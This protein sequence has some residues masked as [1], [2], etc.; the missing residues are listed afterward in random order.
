[1]ANGKP[2]G[3]VLV[4]AMLL[5][6]SS[7]IALDPRMAYLQYDFGTPPT[8]VNLP[9]EIFDVTQD[10]GGFLWLATASGLIRYDGLEATSYRRSA[11]PGLPSNNVT[12]LFVDSRGRLFVSSERGT[13]FRDNDAFV[14]LL[15]GSKS[16]TQAHAFAEGPAG[17]IWIGTNDALLRF[18]GDRVTAIESPDAPERI[19]SLLWY[20]DR[21]YIGGRARIWIRNG[22]SLSTIELPPGFS[23]AHVRDLVFHQGH[24]WAAT[25]SGLFRLE[26]GRAV[27]VIREELDGLA[28]EDLLAD[29]DENLWFAGRRFIGR[30]LPDGRIEIPDLEDNALGY[31]PEITALYE[32]AAGQHWHTSRFFGLNSVRD[33]PVSRVSYA[34]GLPSTNVTALAANREGKIFVATDSGVSSVFEGEIVTV[35]DGD[36]S[37]GRSI[38][39]IKVADDGSLWVGTEVELLILEPEGDAW[40]NR[41]PPIEVAAAVNA[42]VTGSGNTAWI[43]TDAGLYR[44]SGE[45]LEAVPESSDLTFESLLYDSSGTLWLGTDVG[46]AELRGDEIVRN[47]AE[48]PE[49]V[50]TIVGI[51]EL[52]NRHI[53]VAT[54]D[55]GIMIRGDDRWVRFGEEDGLPPEQIIGIEAR[56]PFLWIVTAAGVFRAGLPDLE[57]AAQPTLRVTP[58]AGKALYRPAHTTNCCRGRNA[59]SLVVSNGQ[60]L[61]TSDDGVVFFDTEL[62]TEPAA[63]PRPYI[64]TV[65][66]A[67]GTNLWDA[68][69]PLSLDHDSRDIAIGYSAMQ[70]VNGEQVRFRYRLNGLSENWVSAGRNRSAHFLNLPPGQFEFE[71]QASYMPGLWQG[72]TVRFG[73]ERP[74]SFLETTT[75][76]AVAWLTAIAAG[77]GAIWIW[78]LVARSRHRILDAR[79]NTRT[80]ELNSLNEELRAVNQ[81]LKKSNQTDP[82]TGLVN[83]R[84]FTVS[85]NASTL[86]NSVPD[87]G[88]VLMID[89]DFFKQVNDAYGHAAGDEVLRQFAGSLQA[90]MRQSDLVARWGGEE[91]LAICS[92][93]DG[94][95][96]AMLER[97]CESIGEQCYRVS[98]NVQ[99]DLSCSIGGVR[100]PLRP[101]ETFDAQFTNLLEIADAALYAVKMNGRD[102]WA[103]IEATGLAEA[104]RR[105]FRFRPGQA[106]HQL[107]R[108]IDQGVL[109][110][111]A[112]RPEIGLSMG[113]TVTR[114]RAIRS[115]H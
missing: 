105:A 63:S 66:D 43:G 54:A 106:A 29:R 52:P 113:D 85:R 5:W 60:L 101:G 7:A 6:A 86:D 3:I 23:R 28:F 70:L 61:T 96:A 47:V 111:T 76:R 83:R 2:L 91:F 38:R 90:V 15:R 40:V 67:G 71:L 45:E 25:R 93:P 56:G 75:F 20:D 51:T 46:I 92:C 49:P 58:V 64:K 80:A 37:R 30:F 87:S 89:I 9:S 114:L 42:V 104:D 115:K 39:S 26:A 88:L 19:R 110:W 10:A 11:H 50:S 69:R 98:P 78:L 112:R 13:S 108:R 79:I 97:L 14:P 4:G 36:F 82:L 95:A 74:P 73:F 84:F 24:I 48:L 62:S 94:D 81:E 41:T 72:E 17:S 44:V 12:K 22:S 16:A 59:A 109:E 27:P 34:E 57:N 100:Y 77:I 1:M 65:T 55:H 33:T 68:G 107:Q 31:S 103:C 99:I 53:A 18:D 35:V 32:D 102:G 21:L 8:D